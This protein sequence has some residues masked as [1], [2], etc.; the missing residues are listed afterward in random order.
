MSSPRPSERPAPHAAIGARRP[1]AEVVLPGALALAGALLTLLCAG[2]ANTAAALAAAAL[3]L[4]GAVVGRVLA[5]RH[6]A[7]LEALRREAADEIAR[8]NRLC[9]R[10]APVWIR[11]IETVRGEADA[12]VGELA[13]AFADIAGKLDKVMGPARS[14]SV[15][16]VAQ[17]EILAALARNA[18]ELGRLVTTLRVL[19]ASKERI[20][21]EIGVQAAQLK[22]NASDIRQIALHIRMVSLNATIEAARAGIAG[23]PFGVIVADMRELAA[24][25][26]EASEMFSRHTDR[27]HGLVN[28]A[29]DEQQ[30]EGRQVASIAAAEEVVQQVIDSSEGMTRQLTQAIADMA[31]ERKDVRGDISRALVALQFQD[32][33][34]QILSHVSRNLEEMQARSTAGHWSATDERQWLDRMAR[35]YSTHEEFGNHGGGQL[36][37]AAPGAAVT[38]F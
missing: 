25:T 33:V 21:D 29:F 32:R 27:L 30:Q 4:S 13:R 24:R 18:E 2:R 37:A 38:F 22:E 35:D 31:D 6:A 1:S 19:Q 11:Q 28:A 34:S 12:Q 5:R 10:S 15:E 20:V 16:G 17:D 26:A 9:A 14:D 7:A 23:K 8:V 3:L 36:A